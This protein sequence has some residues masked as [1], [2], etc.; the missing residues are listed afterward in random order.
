MLVL[1]ALVRAQL[2]A[3]KLSVAHY[4]GREEKCTTLHLRMDIVIRYKVY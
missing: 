1:S 2:S 4:C 3:C